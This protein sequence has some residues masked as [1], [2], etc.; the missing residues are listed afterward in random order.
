[1]PSHIM[2]HNEL[3][4][5]LYNNPETGLISADKL[6]KKAKQI[7]ATITRKIVNTFY[8]SYSQ[9]QMSSVKRDKE[10]HF[11]IVSHN[12]D[13]WQIDL[14][15]FKDKIVLVGIN[16]NSRVGYLRLLADKKQ[17]TVLDAIKDFVTKKKV[18]VITSD[19]GSEFYNRRVNNYLRQNSIRQFNAAPGDHS[20][21]GLV[22]RFIR[23]I[24]QRLTKI[25]NI[26]LDQKL[27]DKVVSNYNNTFHS[28]LNATPK[29]K[30]GVVNDD[31]IVYNMQLMNDVAD[32]Y[33]VGKHVRYKLEK[34]N[35]FA[36]ESSNKW[37]ESVYKIINIDGYKLELRSKNGHTLYKSPNDVILVDADITEATGNSKD[38]IY[39]AEKILSHKYVGRG[40]KKQI[41][42][43]VL[44]TDGTQTYEPEKNLRLVEKNKPSMLE[45]A[46]FKQVGQLK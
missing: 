9:T 27:L 3:L 42:Y 45:E 17:D 23:T 32:K 2:S 44:W 12:P 18:K 14:M 40:S 6:Y 33:Q 25:R 24:K 39:E 28:S 34:E 26:K 43:L 35:P 5:R 37:S 19:N 41:R 30:Q 15:F 46:Y 21:L 20:I 4:E 11:K 1:M 10:P 7:D 22:D 38:N 36:K 8:K 31:D 16:I 29:Q 13:S